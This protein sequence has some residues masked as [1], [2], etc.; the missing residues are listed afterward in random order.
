MEEIKCP[1]C[2]ETWEPEIL[3]DI[4]DCGCPSCRRCFD[5]ED[6]EMYE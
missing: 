6:F 5:L 2:G 1:F 3:E 4:G